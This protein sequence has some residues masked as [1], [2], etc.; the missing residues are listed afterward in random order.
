MSNKIILSLIMYNQKMIQ[1]NVTYFRGEDERRYIMRGR[2]KQ[3]RS[4]MSVAIDYALMNI[5]NKLK[6]FQRMISATSPF[7]TLFVQSI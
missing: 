3:G 5:S 7:V 2:S 6:L 4:A 1:R